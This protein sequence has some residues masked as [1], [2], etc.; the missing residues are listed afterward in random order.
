[1]GRA[2]PSVVRK[3]CQSLVIFASA[4]LAISC[5]SVDVPPIP[6]MTPSAL[7][8]TAAPAAVASA[9]IASSDDASPEVEAV[10]IG[11]PTP[12][13]EAGIRACG[14]RERA[15]QIQG[16]GILSDTNL[17]A[18]YLPLTGREP[19]IKRGGPVFAV[20][21]SGT[22]TLP[23]RAGGAAFVDVERASC[24]FLDGSPGWWVTGPW[25][26]FCWSAGNAGAGTVHGQDAA[27]ATSLG[28][29]YRR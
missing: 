1:M 21:F 4:T 23:L 18:H 3:R 28:S 7:A 22:I 29:D 19:E 15:D 6:P 24:V 5:V 25:V 20:L 13:A 26:D 10:S 2:A 27:D 17:L 12:M 11:S 14:V 9:V 16:I 8:S